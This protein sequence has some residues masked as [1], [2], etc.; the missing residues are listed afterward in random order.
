MYIF[1]SLF[2]F[3]FIQMQKIK[4]KIKTRCP[5]K[6]Y[7][8]IFEHFYQNIK[9]YR[10]CKKICI[11]QWLGKYFCLLA[12]IQAKQ[13][14]GE[15]VRFDP[16]T[17]DESGGNPIW[18]K[19][20]K[21]YSYLILGPL[22]PGIKLTKKLLYKCEH[23]FFW[24]TGSFIENWPHLSLIQAYRAWKNVLKISQNMNQWGIQKFQFF[25]FF[26]DGLSYK[27]KQFFYLFHQSGKIGKSN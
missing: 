15:Q 16:I 19:F 8:A 24:K 2:L 13:G 1:L 25:V 18:G 5:K 11:D 7:D 12:G 22:F 3:K 27:N 17:V 23:L 9:A 6:E 14:L 26:I 20:C 4:N 10:T 21:L